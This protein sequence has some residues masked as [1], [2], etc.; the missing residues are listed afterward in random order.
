MSSEVHRPRKP[1]ANPNGAP[2]NPNPNPNY[3]RKHAPI[4]HEQSARSA[5]ALTASTASPSTE[6]TPPSARRNSNHSKGK[7]KRPPKK[8]G[9]GAHGG[10]AHGGGAHGG[11]AHGGG[12]HG[13]GANPPP[14]QHKVSPPPL[15]FDS[16]TFPS[17]SLSLGETAPVM[18]AAEGKLSGY[19]AALKKRN[20]DCV[21]ER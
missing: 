17:L 2:Q 15:R 12:A 13:G 18:S 5:P 16:T 6:L 19:A 7:P 11:G 4:A 3:P 10:G 20:Q 1:R 8:Q 9:G 21:M 14:N